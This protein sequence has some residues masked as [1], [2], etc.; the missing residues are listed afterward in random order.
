MD[1][2]KIIDEKI[3]L[4]YTSDSSI[5]ERVRG[6]IAQ[7]KESWD[8]AQKN[9]NDF[10]R[11][12]TKTFEFEQFKIVVQFNPG[13]LVSSSAMVDVK[14]ID[15]R[16]CFLCIQNLPQEQRGLIYKDEYLILVNPFPIFREHFTIPTLK[17]QPQEIANSFSNML[18]LGKELGKHYSVFYNGPKCGASAP[19]HLHFQACTKSVLPIETELDEIVSDKGELLY[20]HV[21]TAVYGLSNYLRN[22]FLIQT[23][24][25]ESAIIQ[26][27]NLQTII[28][29]SS[30]TSDEPMMNII[31]LYDKIWKIFVFPR[32]KHR[33]T[34]YF[35]EGND[36][37]LVSPAAADFGGQ[38][39]IPRE[40]DFYKITKE[41]IEN[42]FAQTSMSKNIFEKIGSN[43]SALARKYAG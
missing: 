20:E 29:R 13:R 42:I 28:K 39:I 14:S 26:F 31:V 38:L 43:Y 19:D 23:D 6:L 41:N 35:L 16:P 12:E 24:K 21:N 36:R 5:A 9:Y 22:F 37:M 34:Q 40:E 25:K 11:I 33:P 1:S 3:L 32:A 10:N 17:H 4:S 2:S 15:N 8:L 18:D 27:K 7:Q 30:D